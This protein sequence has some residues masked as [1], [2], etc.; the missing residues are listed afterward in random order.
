MDYPGDEE[1]GSQLSEEEQDEVEE[2]EENNKENKLPEY[3]PSYFP[4]FPVIVTAEDTEE[5]AVVIEPKIPL[6]APAA[7][8]TAAAGDAL[9]LPNIVKKKKRPID[10]PFTYLK[11][12]EDSIC[13]T[14]EKDQPAA[15]SLS[16]AAVNRIETPTYD[17]IPR[18]RRRSELLSGFITDIDNQDNE[19][20]RS[21]MIKEDVSLSGQVTRDLA[22]PG[23]TMF[24]NEKGLLDKLMTDLSDPLAIP[25]L[26]TPNLLMDIVPPPT[27]SI[28]PSSTLRLN[29]ASSKTSMG[30][31]TIDKIPKARSVTTPTAEEEIVPQPSQPTETTITP[32][33]IK[34][35]PV[36]LASLSSSSPTTKTE[37]KRKKVK[38]PKEKK[39]KSS[40]KREKK[41]TLPAI[42]TTISHDE[43][44]PP[45]LS[46]QPIL[47]SP[48]NTTA[49]PKIRIK[50]KLPTPSTEEQTPAASVV[51]PAAPATEEISTTATL[52]EE[53]SA[54]DIINCI[55]EFPT[56]D[57]G[58]FMIACDTCRVWYHGQCVGIAESDQV[59]EWHC[60]R[61]RPPV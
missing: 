61:C 4:A 29:M 33:T 20:R 53:T 27:G 28:T 37:E 38:A 56:E 55:C 40:K 21:K 54:T 34:L 51:A 9:P 1:E 46:A 12:L 47:E 17:N 50:F 24:A 30:G 18:R 36:S 48:S 23:N 6:P 45:S 13:F 35:A 42:N 11:S 25:K 8:A 7:A 43:P 31:M 3:V 57:Y 60:S 58:H 26:M 59:E 10:N 22:A 15:L 44:T 52:P 2:M 14:E 16:A 32:T 49:T 19:P 41:V 5:H 39:P